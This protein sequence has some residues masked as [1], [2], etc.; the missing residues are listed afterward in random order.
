MNAMTHLAQLSAMCQRRSDEES[1]AA[2][3]AAVES[4][5]CRRAWIED[6]VSE[7]YALQ[8]HLRT[9]MLSTAPAGLNDALIL[10][11]ALF[12]HVPDMGTEANFSESEWGPIHIAIENIVVALAAACADAEL[13]RMDA[14]A[15]ELCRRRASWRSLPAG[16]EA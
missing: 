9:A 12:S 3:A 16:A 7:R 2:H 13:G 4:E 6:A 8:E 1:A 5:P 10:A 11:L 15:L 14:A